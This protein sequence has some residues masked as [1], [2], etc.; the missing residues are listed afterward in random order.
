[1]TKSKSAITMLILVLLLGLF[2]YTAVSGFGHVAGSASD[3]KFVLIFAR[4]LTITY[5]VVGEE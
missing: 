4:G 2:G 5:Q 1:M 3:I